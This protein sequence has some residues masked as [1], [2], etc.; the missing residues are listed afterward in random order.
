M[1]KPICPVCR[2]SV[3]DLKTNVVRLRRFN[4]LQRMS[5]LAE[6][7]AELRVNWGSKL[8]WV[9]KALNDIRAKDSS[10]KIIAFAQWEDLRRQL[11]VA[12]DSCGVKHVLLEGDIFDRTH[13]LQRFREEDD[14]PLLLL[15]LAESAS[16]TNL[17]VASHVFLLHPMLAAS[18]E[19]AAAFEAQAIG[20]VRRLGQLKPV[21]VWRFV[22][23]DSIEQSLWDLT[24]AS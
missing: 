8:A 15:S 17:T 7:S 12:L 16:G 6:P 9:L 1:Q 3:P 2:F 10:A 19:E 24:S 23:Q 21:H 4:D 18:A 20:R 22:M 13:A 11:S 14:L 5:R